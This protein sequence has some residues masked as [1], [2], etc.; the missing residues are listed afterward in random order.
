M[1]LRNDCQTQACQPI[2]DN[3]RAI[4]IERCSADAAPIKLGPAHTGADT[5]DNEG[6]L[7]LR[8]RRHN[9]DDGPSEGPIRIDGFALRQELDPQVAQLIEYLEKMFRTPGEAVA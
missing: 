4:D 9:H 3:L 2:T 6:P 1:L 8:H 5:F 7:Q